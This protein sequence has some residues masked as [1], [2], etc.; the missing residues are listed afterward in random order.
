MNE[1]KL[2]LHNILKQGSLEPEFCIKQLEWFYKTR[3]KKNE[4]SF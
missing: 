2:F 1:L 3:E 4:N